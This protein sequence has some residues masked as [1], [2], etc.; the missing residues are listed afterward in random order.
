MTITLHDLAVFYVESV[1][2][3]GSKNGLKCIYSQNYLI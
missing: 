3:N 1:T 2:A